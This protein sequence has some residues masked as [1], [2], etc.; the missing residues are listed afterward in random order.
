MMINL[1]Q[2]WCTY[3]KTI[4]P[5]FSLCFN[6]E[7]HH[8]G[9]TTRLWNCSHRRD[10]NSRTLSIAARCRQVRTSHCV[11]F[12]FLKVK[13]RRSSHQMW[14]RV[15]V[16]VRPV[17]DNAPS[18]RSVRRQQTFLLSV[19][20]TPRR[21]DQCVSATLADTCDNTVW[22]PDPALPCVFPALLETAQRKT[23]TN[24]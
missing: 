5:L 12:I 22:F 16:D 14:T 9:Q 1:Y 7:Q 15:F 17:W 20:W 13:C 3:D 4:L 10:Q 23:S 21:W 18:S 19:S 8:D 11:H 24:V 2:S 6:T